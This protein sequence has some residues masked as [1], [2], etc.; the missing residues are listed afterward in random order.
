MTAVRGAIEPGRGVIERYRDFLP[1]CDAV[2]SLGEGNTPLILSPKLARTVSD[3]AAKSSSSTRA[4]SDRLIQGSRH[5]CRGFES[6]G[7]GSKRLIC[8]STGNTSASAAAYAA[9]A[10]IRCAV[11]LPAGKIAS[12]KLVQAFAY[13]AKI[14]RD[15]RKFR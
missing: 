7:A 4:Q 13:G 3:A 10:G 12:G 14:V 1:A 2:V 5:D 6:G 15:R 11:I 8:A 9:R